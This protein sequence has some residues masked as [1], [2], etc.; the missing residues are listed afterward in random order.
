MERD[1]II[2][3]F[4][5]EIVKEDDS[6]IR[7]VMFDPNIQTLGEANAFKDGSFR[8]LLNGDKLSCFYKL[9]FILHHEVGHVILGHFNGRGSSLIREEA[10]ADEYAVCRQGLCDDKNRIKEEWVTCARCMLEKREDC[11]KVQPSV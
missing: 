2:N 8:I 11:L 5:T 6:R 3:D 1:I 10:E 7:Y 4:L 9:M